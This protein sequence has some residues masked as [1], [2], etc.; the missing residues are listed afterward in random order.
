MLLSLR[1]KAD[2]NPSLQSGMDGWTTNTDYTATYPRVPQ[3]CVSGQQTR[4]PCARAG[5]TICGLAADEVFGQDQREDQSPNAT[6]RFYRSEWCGGMLDRKSTRL[7]S[8]HT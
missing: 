2:S 4:L 7:N 8:S 6:R 5:S 1:F 3:T